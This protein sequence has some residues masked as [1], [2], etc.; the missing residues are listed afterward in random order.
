MMAFAERQTRALQD[1]SIQFSRYLKASGA[2]A[3]V[4]KED[5]KGKG[6]QV[7]ADPFQ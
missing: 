6:K 1:L 5:P 4:A 3:E 2:G 7:E